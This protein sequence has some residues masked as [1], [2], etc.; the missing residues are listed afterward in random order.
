MFWRSIHDDQKEDY[1]LFFASGW[2]INI[3]FLSIANNDSLCLC[4]S[5]SW[6]TRFYFCNDTFV[7]EFG[8]AI[9][10]YTICICLVLLLLSPLCLAETPASNNTEN[11]NVGQLTLLPITPGLKGKVIVI[12]PGFGGADPGVIGPNGIPEKTITLAVALKVKVLLEQAGAKVIMTRMDDRDVFGPNG[13]AVEEAKARVAVGNQNKADVFVN[14]STNYFSNSNASGT[15]TY[16]YQKSIYDR[17]LAKSIQDSVIN[18]VGTNNR[19]IYPANFYVLK[20]TLM[21]AILIQ[22][23]FQSNPKEEMLLSAPKSQQ[24]LAQGI[25]NGLDN[26]FAQAAM[27]RN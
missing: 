24:K 4:K 11:I 8:G 20:H 23:G 16:Y 1:F 27:D 10:R 18:A 3:L 6:K 26:F 25:Y 5:W 17:L 2:I 15:V 21:P 12:D 19:G 22:L 7:D 14:I 13:S 9:L